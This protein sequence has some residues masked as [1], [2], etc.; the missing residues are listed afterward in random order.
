MFLVHDLVILPQLKEREMKR[1]EIRLTEKEW[2]I[3][4]VA[5]KENLR[6]MQ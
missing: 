2:V 1:N 3:K 5:M 6:Q 4:T